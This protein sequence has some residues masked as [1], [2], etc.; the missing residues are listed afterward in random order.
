MSSH[1]ERQLLKSAYPASKTWA[2]KVDKMP[3]AQ[4]VAVLMRLKS[5]GVLK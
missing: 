4:V 2:Q 5:K 1:V 3:D